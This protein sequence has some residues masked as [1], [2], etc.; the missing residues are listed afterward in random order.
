MRRDRRRRNGFTLIEMLVVIAI[1]ATLASV[2]APSLLGNVSE[3]KRTAA[4]AQLEVFSLALDSYQLDVGAYPSEAEGL[5]ALRTAPERDDERRR[6]RGPYL[7]QEVPLDPWGRPWVY[8]IPGKVNP[9]SYDLYTL[10]KDGRIGGEGEN[11]D[12]T[13]WKGEVSP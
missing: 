1:I 10:G 12:V 3:A 9:G 7:R 6:W 4:S 2:V 8:R 13:A 5:Q 11:S